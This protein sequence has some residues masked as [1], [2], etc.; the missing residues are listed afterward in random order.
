MLLHSQHNMS[1]DLSNSRIA[2]AQLFKLRETFEQAVADVQKT[3]LQP[4]HTKIF[5]INMIKK[6][7]A[8]G[9]AKC[10]AHSNDI[11]PSYAATEAR[12]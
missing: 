10:K 3:L 6:A 11:E 12:K 8:A 7:V 9:V 4:Q 1:P 2:S 5:D